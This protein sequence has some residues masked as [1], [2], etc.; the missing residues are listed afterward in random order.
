MKTEID[1]MGYE[2]V[3]EGADKGRLATVESAI[4]WYVDACYGEISDMSKEARGFRYRFDYTN[5]TFAELEAECDYWAKEAQAAY[6]EEQARKEEDV[7][8]FK[9]L[10]AK[11]IDLGAGDEETA[12]RWL[13]D[14]EE[15]YS[16]QDVEHWVWDK[17][18]L[19]TDYGKKLVDK[20]LSI[21]KFKSFEYSV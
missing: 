15:F 2:I 18:I 10:V 7:A 20:L 17:G 16:G 12:L 6:A 8:E 13:I 9:Q 14:G 3:S 4:E 5:M 19:F 1:F 11:T 21:A